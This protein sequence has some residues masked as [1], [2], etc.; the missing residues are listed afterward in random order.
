MKK[1]LLILIL[2]IT[3]VSCNIINDCDIWGAKPQLNDTK[4][5]TGIV[6]SYYEDS[7]NAEID[8]NPNDNGYYYY[9]TVHHLPAGMDYEVY[10]R[11]LVLFGTPSQ[12]G[13]YSIE[14]ELYVEPEFWDESYEGDGLCT[15][16]TSKYYSL[17]IKS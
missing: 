1:L 4:L 12:P 10:G 5:S 6:D 3:T 7:L 13:R 11:E 14:V 9:F 17:E 15:D 2:A 8:N 16:T